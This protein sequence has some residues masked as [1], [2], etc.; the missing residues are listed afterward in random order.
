MLVCAEWGL[1]CL[2]PVLECQ[3]HVT[4]S[5]FKTTSHSTTHSSTYVD[6]LK[7]A[8]DRYTADEVLILAPSL[9][10]PHSRQTSVYKIT[11]G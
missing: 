9:K 3:S 4:A 6:L 11:A 1:E 8:I 10:S 2:M 7:E 5:L